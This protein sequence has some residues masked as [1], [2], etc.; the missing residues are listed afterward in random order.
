MPSKDHFVQRSYSMSIDGGDSPSDWRT[1]LWETHAAVSRGAAEAG[2]QL[3]TLRGGLPASLAAAPPGP[4][5][6]EAVRWRRTVLALSW[7]TVES[8][9]GAP[10]GFVIDDPVRALQGILREEGLDEETVASWVED[11]GPT[12]RAAKREDSVRVDRRAAWHASPAGKDGHGEEAIHDLFG[13]LYGGAGWLD[14]Y[15]SMPASGAEAGGGPEEAE[16]AEDQDDEEDDGEVA[17]QPEE[18]G[19]EGKGGAP[20]RPRTWLS[21]RAGS[22]KGTDFGVMHAIYEAIAA[23]LPRAP[24]GVGG[25]E[26]LRSLAVALQEFGPGS[27][28]AQGVFDLMGIGEK[29]R[30]KTD[31]LLLEIRGMGVVPEEFLGEVAE[32]AVKN[33]AGTSGSIG[34]KGRRP[35]SDVILRAIG[36]ACGFD[37]RRKAGL[38]SCGE[39]SSML[40]QALRRIRALHT[41]ATK[42]AVRR[43]ALERQAREIET[44]PPAARQ[45]LDR[46]C[47][48]RSVDT[49]A[50][51][52]YRM[53]RGAL[54]GWSDVVAAWSRAGCRTVGQREEA[55]RQMQ[56]EGG[57]RK[58]GDAAL[59]EALAAE[60]AWC[61][62]HDGDRADD[63]ILVRYQAAA[64]S[65]RRMLDLKV[66][67]YRHPD[68]FVHPVFC[69]FSDNCW[70]IKFGFGSGGAEEGGKKGGKEE[71]EG[72][73]IRDV[74]MSLWN[75]EAVVPVK[76]QWHSK[77]FFRD[78]ASCSPPAGDG[79][80]PAVARGDRVGRMLAGAGEAGPV[81]V[82]EFLV[83]PWN[84]RLQAPRDQ[85]REIARLPA[86]KQPAA[87][88]R[89]RWSVGFS[90]RLLPA[91]PWIGYA[92]D[93]DLDPAWPAGKR[94]RGR[95]GRARH[96]LSCLPGMRVLSVDL[97]QRNTLACA[98]WQAVSGAEVEE[99]ARR[100]KVSPPTATDLYI[101]IPDGGRRTIYRRIGPDRLAATGGREGGLHP[102]PWARLDR[103][104]LVH[105]QGE[106]D[107]RK[108]SREEIAA[109]ERLEV[110]LGRQRTPETP[111]PARVDRIMDSALRTAAGGLRRH[112][113]RARIA[114]GLSGGGGEAGRQDAVL[115]ALMLWYGLATPG[116]WRDDQAAR[117]WEEDVAPL[118]P[119]GGLPAGDDGS[120]AARRK[121]LDEVRA[122]LRPVAAR[123]LAGGR[124]EE[125]AGRWRE[126]WTME[127]G[128]QGSAGRSGWY[129]RLRWL[130]DWILPSGSGKDDGSI[131]HVG[132]LSLGRI[133]VMRGVYRL[134]QAFLM[135]PTPADP[136]GGAPER[137]RTRGPAPRAGS[138]IRKTM[139]H[140]REDRARQTASRIVAAAAGL[141]NHQRPRPGDPRYAPC[142]AVVIENLRHY[143][144]DEERSRRENR[145]LQ[146]W[147]AGAVRRHLTDLCSL[148]G[149]LLCEVNPAYTS[150]QDSRTG[151]PGM[152]CQDV[153]VDRFLGDAWSRRL[154]RAEQADRAG[155][156]TA[157]DRLLVC[158]AEAWRKQGP[159]ARRSGRVL[160]PCPGG[161][162]FVPAAVSGNH[163]GSLQADLNAAGNIGL[164]ALTDPDWP[165]A[166][167]YV[168][169]DRSTAVPVRDR[170]RGCRTVPDR[171]MCD[172]RT[173][174]AAGRAAGRPVNLWRDVS[175]ERLEEGTW[176]PYGPYRVGVMTRV[177]LRLWLWAEHRLA[178][179]A[180]GRKGGPE[181]APV[182]SAATL[183]LPA[184]AR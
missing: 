65:R 171:A 119:A 51:A 12:L 172:P 24:R 52:A 184:G 159:A 41:L 43:A 133:G 179:G 85:L 70:G 154:G 47:A 89:I 156:G 109:V 142:H 166:W 63:G 36:R 25:A 131:R 9:A 158:L 130:R 113:L 6:R 84:G 90:A 46:Y 124:T 32:A 157:E 163:L 11:C 27:P 42:A 134:Q 153:P 95:T 5:S 149:L 120:R 33:A 140:L 16:A 145:S 138:R 129:A 69:E 14:A 68:P 50:V 144:P 136:R 64:Q 178:A 173:L 74:Q 110:D 59:F 54:G 135:R 8:A 67:L 101:S 40:D 118:L 35:W 73:R 3:L 20:L 116:Y 87:I 183:A 19:T 111:L 1:P 60:D 147:C 112:G 91:G 151:A 45:W 97:G 76:L 62:W 82:P 132:G 94:D 80:P 108:G 121:H 57:E 150:R 17:G 81:T 10:V 165:G 21:Q 100:A 99:H 107:V 98:V 106:E 48:T 66:P 180:E 115:E 4:G 170:V 23:W 148:N 122:V 56:A 169:V 96:G 182:R 22:G 164:R 93:H 38:D 34:V 125:I 105:L 162:L 29:G 152:R 18:K 2:H 83:Q 102:A 28:D 37:Y 126:M 13:R 160:V 88:R 78:L 79:T 26:V 168:A 44:I 7:I 117:R 128:V 39:Y 15:F 174:G 31:K 86:E 71:E 75:G 72:L 137:G 176:V 141:D 181:R 92:A 127:D 58:F 139:E 175:A 55:V 53:R 49:G 61:V 77:R 155:R 167:W 161:D 143:R 123:L 30:R 104:F 114:H 177:C 146:E 103:Q